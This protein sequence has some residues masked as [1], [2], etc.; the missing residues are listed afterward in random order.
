[1]EVRVIED[2]QIRKSGLKFVSHSVMFPSILGDVFVE[3]C[4][5]SHLVSLQPAEVF[6]VVMYNLYYLHL[7]FELSTPLALLLN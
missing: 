7:I 1:M 2:T 6:N 4:Q 5:Y 3:T